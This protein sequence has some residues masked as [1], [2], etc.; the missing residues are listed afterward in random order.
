MS[1][2]AP[3]PLL[4]TKLHVPPARPG[5]VA[6]TRLMEQLDEGM[7]TRLTLVSAPAGF[8]KSTVVSQ[9]AA[10]CGR[11]VAWLS[12][13]ERDD[14]PSSFLTY[15]VAALRTIAPDVG[16][17]VVAVLQSPQPPPVEAILTTLLNEI[18]TIPGDLVLVLDDYHVLDSKPD[19][20][21]LAFLLE[22]LPPQ[23]HLVIAT[24]EDPRLPLARLRARGH[25]TELRD[26]ELRFTPAEAAEFLRRVMGL[27]LSPE[28]IAALD[29]RTEGWIAGL[30]MAAISI[31]GAPDA[32]RFI[33][34][35]TGSHRFV[36]DYLL[37]EVLQRQPDE[38]R[39]FL[40]CTS[41]LDRLCGPLC[42]AVLESPAGSGEE[43]L[44][45][46]EHANL[47]IVALDN[48]RHWYRYHQLFRDLLRHR[49]ERSLSPVEIAELHVRASEWCELNGQLLEAFRHAA[50]A[51]DVDRAERL[52]DSSQM[53]LHLRSVVMPILDWLASL[54]PSVLDARPRLW[55]R[56]AT[57][58]L[59]AVQTTGVEEKL[60][61]AEVLLQGVD[62]DEETRDLAGQIA[63]A[64]ATLALTRYDPEEM[65]A[66]ALRARDHLRPD[67]LPF[68]FTAAWVA[69]MAHL[70]AGDRAAAARACQECVELSERSGQVFARILTAV[71]LGNVQESDNQLHR[72]AES[73]RRALGLAGEY[74]LPNAE[75][76]HLGLARISYEW[77]DLDAAEL[78]GQQS[79]RLA[80]LYDRAIDRSLASDIFLARVAL[81]RGDV[82]AAAAMLA[83]AQ[84]SA[85][86][87][88]FVLRL[89]E[90]AAVQV[91]VLIRQGQVAAAAHLAETYG[92]PLGQARVLIAQSDP[93]AALAVLEPLRQQMEARGW[94]DERLKTIVL[95]A[96]AEHVL[97]E[98]HRAAR[99]LGEALALAEPS[100][101]IRLFV[102]EGAP[103]A[104]ML[105]AAAAQDVR[106][107]YTSRLLAAFA[108]EAERERQPSSAPGPSPSAEL[109]SRRE[110]DVLRL[111]AQGLSN[112]EIGQQLFLALD[113]VKGH[114]RRIFE[115]LQ[116]QRRTEAVARARELGLL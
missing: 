5:A 20:E 56:W 68:R 3:T 37:E 112:Q 92:L 36:L 45:A 51:R 67:N 10:A 72:A 90:I 116:V 86:E 23:M 85:Q 79:L 2:G 59:M 53:D 29:A 100:G 1:A 12:L 27:D 31:Q 42:D 48:E 8:G 54:P 46:V 44:P 21:A 89:P 6:R 106:P 25:L 83:Q 14:D 81:A 95:Q 111:V 35:F 50:L 63:C 97:G 39:T 104:D 30:Q 61:T 40:L 75:E 66:Q 34:S 105:S 7:L 17:T 65:T 108:A 87:N 69:T 33:R 58:A 76:V 114:N 74:P 115:K 73:Y 84:L 113:T 62:L 28:D 19:D 91:L 102:D 15:V 52:I 24:R 11:P 109:L 38:I 93:S 80:R 49:L 26:A 41:V 70:F 13:D 94:A 18:T 78:H 96:V 32:A 55:V 88:G 22:H 4:F 110:L 16:R 64:R 101:F 57:L 71:T 107:E 103:M 99:S 60:Q 98:E 43:T 47:F 77:N 9:W 82:E